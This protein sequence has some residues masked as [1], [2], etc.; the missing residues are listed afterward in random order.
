MNRFGPLFLFSF[1]LAFAAIAGEKPE[2]AV[3]PDAGFARRWTMGA[4]FGPDFYYGD[5]NRY[6]LG[7]SGNLSLAGALTFHYQAS[8]IFGARLKLSGAWLNGSGTYNTGTKTETVPFTGVLV[9]GDLSAVI[10]FT[11][12]FS[13]YHADRW[14]FIYGTVGIGYGGWY[15]KLVN[16]VYDA[17]SIETDNPLSNFRSALVIPAGPGILF[18]AGRRVNISIEYTFNTF[19]SD[20]LDQT[21]G[22]KSFDRYDCLM[23]G[24][25][26]NLG[27][28]GPRR[29]KPGNYKVLD[30]TVGLPVTV[31]QPQP[32]TLRVVMPP[33]EIPAPVQQDEFL[34]A[35]QIFAFSRH[36]YTPDWIRKHYRIPVQVRVEKEGM[37]ER[38]MA[39]GMTG[40]AE[41]VRLRDDMIRLGIRDAFIVAYKNGSRHHT[42]TR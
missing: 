26:I 15:T 6:K 41:A 39:G 40:L 14:F 22:G 21:G 38:F 18:R 19:N 37:V 17:G 25:G 16:K 11:N 30:Y 32:A 8:T 4:G 1:L 10:N 27:K 28:Q 35:V 36:T 29:E 2:P 33:P 13:P 31:P 20:M 34:Y 42:V 9:Q 3:R 5:L 7:I 24:I 23:L 12:L